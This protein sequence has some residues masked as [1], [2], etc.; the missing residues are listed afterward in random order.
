MSMTIMKVF[1]AIVLL[2]IVL[3]LTLMSVGANETDFHIVSMGT[4]G[5][6]GRGF[7]YLSPAAINEP[8]HVQIEFQC[9]SEHS[10][11]IS[12]VS[13]FPILNGYSVMKTPENGDLP[14]YDPNEEL[15]ISRS[16]QNL[17]EVVLLSPDGAR[18]VSP[19][20]TISLNFTLVLRTAGTWNF[21]LMISTNSG[22]NYILSG[23]TMYIARN[24]PEYL[25][26]LTIAVPI[27]FGAGSIGVVVL[28][29]RTHK[30]KR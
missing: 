24:L 21:L 27:L 17:Y 22:E 13:L 28:F 29:D 9:L 6:N 3:P 1:S 14:A 26:T 8:L 10:I 2:I 18:Q 5:D 19:T 23:S 15:N 7:D 12:S 20:E 11:N 16:M 4:I 30:L 25:N